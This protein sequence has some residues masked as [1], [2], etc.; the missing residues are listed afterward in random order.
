MLQSPDQAVKISH[1]ADY[2][3]DRDGLQPAEALAAIEQARDL[4][5][6]TLGYTNYGTNQSAYWILI[7]VRNASGAAEWVLTTTNHLFTRID[8]YAGPGLQ[9]VPVSQVGDGLFGM[10]LIRHARVT[11]PPATDTRLLVRIEA[12]VMHPPYLRLHSEAQARSLSVL[13]TVVALL[14]IGG[15]AGLVLYNLLIALQLRSALY[16]MYCAY[17]VTHLLFMMVVCGVMTWLLGHG[18]GDVHS[19]TYRYSALSV[20][21][22]L[23][24]TTVFMRSG[25][26][27]KLPR[28]WVAALL[29]MAAL[30]YGYLLLSLIFPQQS[31]HVG[32]LY[33]LTYIVSLVLILVV[34]IVQRVRGFEAAGVFLLGW[35]ILA[36]AYLLAVYHGLS[37]EH[38]P[39]WGNMVP[40]VAGTIEMV[41]L[42]LALGQRFVAMRRQAE[43]QRQRA[44]RLELDNLRKNEFVQTLTHDIRA[45]LHS[46]MSALELVRSTSDKHRRIEYLDT[47]RYSTETLYDLVDSMLDAVNIDVATRAQI[48]QPFELH[49]LVEATASIFSARASAKNLRLD[50]GDV[51]SMHLHG[52]AIVIRRS[53]INLISNAVKYTDTGSVRVAA[54]VDDTD[55]QNSLLKLVVTDTGPGIDHAELATTT[56]GADVYSVQPSSKV[57]L[58]ISQQIVTKAGGSLTLRRR[59]SGG[60]EARLQVPVSRQPNAESTEPE[61]A[62][63]ANQGRALLVDDDATTRQVLAAAL[64]RAGYQ[65]TH[66]ADQAGAQSGLADTT[67]SLIVCDHR[68]PDGDGFELLKQHRMQGNNAPL[69]LV[70]AVVAGNGDE[71]AQYGI[72]RIQKPV[73]DSALRAAC[74]QAVAVSKNLALLTDPSELAGSLE[75]A[76]RNEVCALFIDQ[77]S[78][79]LS[80][81]KSR[82]ADAKARHVA[83]HR[84]ASAATTLGLTGTREAALAVEA[85]LVPAVE[86]KDIGAAVDPE[87]QATAID[88]LDKAVAA[89][90]SAC[91]V[92]L[93]RGS[94]ATK[95]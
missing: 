5:P 56:P 55:S 1:R 90:V 31:L 64:D 27:A 71:A 47:A 93:L 36:S 66:H 34:A 24:F 40:T 32:A 6:E 92:A 72:I 51:P 33:G 21:T 50:I 86:A 20:G 82:S 94:V 45:P 22:M 14:C 60:T 8:L 10:D 79:D 49:R 52:P 37:L 23:L 3:I 61:A 67:W 74:Q 83:A 38:R 87:Q 2:L 18:D 42:S 48:D 63:K 43:G 75:L 12:E 81:V 11:L 95:A 65:V 29:L 26:Q 41:L 73:P 68:L 69:L 15:T 19:S 44:E 76:Q 7:N 4:A 85:L 78:A 39:Y 88:A 57:G 13:L 25:Q 77:A 16:A 17:G 30:N 58:A 35:G 62:P 28:P 84:L 91:Q 46:V 80:T 54:S 53:L 70:S 59:D 9:Q 89:S